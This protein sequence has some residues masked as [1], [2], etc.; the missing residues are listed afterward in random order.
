VKEPPHEKKKPAPK[1]TKV[2]E[3]ELFKI[4]KT[5]MVEKYKKTGFYK[6]IRDTSQNSQN[7]PKND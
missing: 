5:E 6:N 7:L 1:V 4:S 2:K 3:R